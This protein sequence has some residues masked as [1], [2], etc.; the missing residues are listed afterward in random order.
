METLW[1]PDIGYGTDEGEDNP[2]S[3]GN[4]SFGGNNPFGGEGNNEGDDKPKFYRVND[5][6]VKVISERV[7]IMIRME[8]L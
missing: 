6:P 8:N 3:G 5:V 7:N 1:P 2:T 4:S